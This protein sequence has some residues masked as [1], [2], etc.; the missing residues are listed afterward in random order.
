MSNIGKGIFFK[1]KISRGETFL[2]YKGNRKCIYGL[3]ISCTRIK[4][5]SK[6]IGLETLMLCN[7]NRKVETGGIFANL[8][9]LLP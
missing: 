9:A 1:R 8:F 2:F 7:S 5:P 4:S 3:E 6:G